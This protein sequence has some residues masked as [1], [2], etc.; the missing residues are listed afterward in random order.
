MSTET[1]KKNSQPDALQALQE[2]LLPALAQS[3]GLSQGLVNILGMPEFSMKN[4]RIC[5]VHEDDLVERGILGF[6]RV[7]GNI[8]LALA[9]GTKQVRYL[10]LEKFIALIEKM[11]DGESANIVV[12]NHRVEEKDMRG[13]VIARVN[14]RC[15]AIQ[16]VQG[17]AGRPIRSG[18]DMVS[19]EAYYLPREELTSYY[20]AAK[21]QISNGQKLEDLIAAN[22]GYKGFSIKIDP[23]NPVG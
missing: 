7:S 12:Q 4:G 20:I 5:A 8:V 2:L 6:R 17:V 19:N 21:C 13:Q 1:P 23:L 16:I 11:N 9:C 22:D 14:P 10:P 15:S 18:A 3:D